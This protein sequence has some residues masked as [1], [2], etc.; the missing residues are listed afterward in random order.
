MENASLLLGMIA[1]FL[2]NSC[3]SSRLMG[4]LT[5][6]TP[7]WGPIIA[8]QPATEQEQGTVRNCSH[9]VMPHAPCMAHPTD[10]STFSI[11]VHV[12]AV[13]AK[14]RPWLRLWLAGAVRAHHGLVGLAG[15][16]CGDGNT[17]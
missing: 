17:R 14:H 4:E 13:S 11:G 12:A 7:G 9:H 15:L 2:S 5:V 3:T 10:N 8:W 6:L 1:P 16:F